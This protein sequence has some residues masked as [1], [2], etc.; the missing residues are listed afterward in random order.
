MAPEA[1]GFPVP[2]A[3]GSGAAGDAQAPTKSAR[4]RIVDALMALAAEREWDDFGLADV[5]ERAGV[6]L[7]DF[8]DAFPSKGA[9]L[10]AF[11]RRIDRAVLEGGGPVAFD[12][13]AR[14]RL[15]DVLMRRLDALAPYRAALQ[16]VSE[17]A[18]REPLAAVAL[19]GVVTNSM[20]F[21]LAAAG[22]ENEGARGTLKLQ[23]LVIAWGRVLDAWFDDQDATL[24]KTMAALDRELS[25]GETWVARIDDLDR[26]LSPVRLLMRAVADARRR[27]RDRPRAKPEPIDDYDSGAA[28]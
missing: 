11:S 15:F 24:A 14:E 22:I 17:W 6:S 20:R 21:M 8:R 25:R 16:S 10:A 19:N 13:P 3:G 1:N 23:G 12:E 28:V 27:G 7:A 5:A 4:D 26:L 2:P 9:V 18:R